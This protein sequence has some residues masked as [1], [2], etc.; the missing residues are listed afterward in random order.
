ME[1]VA[2]L[3]HL[4]ISTSE[5]GNLQLEGKAWSIEGVETAHYS[6][7]GVNYDQEDRTLYY[8]WGGKH[9]RD[10]GT[11]DYFGAGEVTFGPKDDI[12]YSQGDGW[13]ST[14]SSSDETDSHIKSTK[15]TRVT[16]EELELLRGT[17]HD[18]LGKLILFKLRERQQ[19]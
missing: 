2:V 15:Y 9:P 14:T 4:E 12:V 19:V 1:V 18:E 13:F 11:P 10:K 17:D 5:Q 3:S 6:S 7:R 8:S 16:P